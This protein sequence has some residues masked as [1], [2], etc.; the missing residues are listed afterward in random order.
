MLEDSYQPSMVLDHNPALKQL[1]E[2]VVALTARLVAL[3]QVP[4]DGMLAELNQAAMAIAGAVL[5]LGQA[6]SISI[7]AAAELRALAVSMATKMP[8]LGLRPLARSTLKELQAAAVAM[9]GKVLALG[10]LT[11]ETVG[12]NIDRST[13][14]CSVCVERS[15]KL[16]ASTITTSKSEMTATSSESSSQTFQQLQAEMA[17]MAGRV[18]GTDLSLQELSGST[19]TNESKS[20]AV[21]HRWSPSSTN[22]SPSRERNLSR[23]SR[24]PVKSPL[25]ASHEFVEQELREEVLAMAAVMGLSV[26]DGRSAGERDTQ[27]LA[28]RF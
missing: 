23:Q 16:W 4:E 27:S 15:E 12:I 25:S 9:A 26:G 1:E 8:A 2:D 3:D 14:R 11:I 28:L 19:L 6:G 5:A 24:S 10:Q 13:D 22:I 21:A 7:E 17:A 18:A 20:T